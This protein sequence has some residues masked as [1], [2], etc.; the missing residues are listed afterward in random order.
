MTLFSFLLNLFSTSKLIVIQFTKIFYNISQKYRLYLK[1]L[2]VP[3]HQGRADTSFSNASDASF[4]SITSLD[5]YDLQ[6]LAASGQIPTQALM[7]LH[8]GQRRPTNIC[9]D[10]STADQRGFF[11]SDVLLANSSKMRPTIVQQ[12]NNNQMSMLYGPSTPM[13]PRQ[14]AQAQQMFLS[15]GNMGLQVSEGTRGLS[16]LPSSLITSSS[17]SGGIINGHSNNSFV[18][19]MNQTGQQ[20]SVGQQQDHIQISV[21]RQ[22][23]PRGQVLNGIASEVSS[24]IGQQMVSNGISNHVLVRT[25]TTINGGT[26]VQGN[27][28]NMSSYGTIPQALHPNVQN[29][30]LGMSGSS[31]HPHVNSTV[32]ANHTSTG[33]IQEAMTAAPGGLE[34]LHNVTSLKEGKDGIPNYDI[35]SDLHQSKNQD[36]KL[37]NINLSYESSQLGTKHSNI[38]YGSSVTTHQDFNATIEDGAARNACTVRKEIFSIRTEIEHEKVECISQDTLFS[39]DGFPNE[40]MSVFGKQVSF[41]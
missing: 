41:L 6:A 13:E 3:Q 31:C 7:T 4:S 26:P 17:F 1:R 21:P 16:S 10:M 27:Y 24:T 34:V 30:G 25:G 20:I 11:H 5:G 9:M 14:I 29:S 23:Q 37:Q 18:V 33:M 8:S 36:W 39:D 32:V 22:P 19:Q 2:T 35:F 28:M 40:L 15:Y 38:D 12:V